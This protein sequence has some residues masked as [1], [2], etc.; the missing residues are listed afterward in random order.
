M[1]QPLFLSGLAAS[2]LAACAAPETSTQT[3]ALAAENNDV[4]TGDYCVGILEYVNEATFSE[5]D[6]YL[7][8]T[9]ATDRGLLS[10]GAS[11]VLPADAEI[12]IS[13]GPGPQGALNRD[14]F[15]LGNLSIE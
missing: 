1:N 3:S 2:L 15:W 8:A 6:S 12:E 10:L 5:L 14:W 4:D 11:F 13:V 9:V 7:P